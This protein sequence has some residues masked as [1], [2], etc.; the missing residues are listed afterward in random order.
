[1]RRR[2]LPPHLVQQFVQ[3]PWR[4]VAKHV[5]EL[6]HEV[7]EARILV[8]DLARQH[9]VQRLD[10]VLHALDVL[11][12]HLVDHA[13][14]IVE[15]GPGHRLA[16]L[17]EQF[18][19]LAL[20]VRIQE[21]VA[22]ERVHLASR[23]LGEVVE[24]FLVAFGD[25]LQDA[26]RVFVVVPVH[27]L[28]YRV[29]LHV[30]DAGELLLD[31]AHHA[32]QV[33]LLK[34]FA[35]AIPQLAHDVAQSLHRLVASPHTAGHQVAQGPA[36]VAILGKVI[37]NGREHVVRGD[38]ERLCPVPPGIAKTCREVAQARLARPSPCYGVS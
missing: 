32:G 30:D 13:L 31:V 10:H 26:I 33:E 28:V 37:G 25:F 24:R 16:Q 23:I 17:V 36:E 14:D 9:F 4:I 20:G 22:L 19:E 5:A 11:A 7:V 21:L 12:G 6:A 29:L 2:H 35:P 3:R 18:Q 34:P 8:P 38:V 1:M 15:E 27:P